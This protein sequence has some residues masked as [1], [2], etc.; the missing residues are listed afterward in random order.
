METQATDRAFRIGQQRNVLVHRSI[1]TATFDER[2]NAMIQSIDRHRSTLGA[3][4]EILYAVNI[5]EGLHQT[6]I[7]PLARLE[8]REAFQPAM[9]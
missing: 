2:I 7:T 4:L 6:G 8:S 9:F 5:R 3:V 1:T